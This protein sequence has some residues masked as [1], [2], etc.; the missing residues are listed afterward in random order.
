M[1]WLAFIALALLLAAMPV[2]GAWAGA[3]ENQGLLKLKGRYVKWGEAAYGR[4]ATVTYAFLDH[5]RGF[6]DAR[7]CT[8]MEPIGDLLQ[9]NGIHRAAFAGEVAAAFRLW[10]AAAGLRFEQVVE[11][12]NADI[13]I[14]GQ[15]DDRGVAFT[16]VRQE[17][18]PARGPIDG[19]GNATICLDPSERWEVGIDGN[20]KTYNL[21]YVLAHEIGHAIGLDHRGRDRG[22]MGFAYRELVR[23]PSEIV[24]APTDIAAAARLYG[25]AARTRLARAAPS[26]PASLRASCSEPEPTPRR[27]LACSLVPGEP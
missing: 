20:P 15:R 9:R 4:K 10:S 2:D 22:I 18:A 25:P 27:D 26:A 14:G 8:A 11:A 1:S 5:P 24:L 6:P 21:R 19:I 3:L 12:G 13:L 23:A 16:N 7:N 17:T